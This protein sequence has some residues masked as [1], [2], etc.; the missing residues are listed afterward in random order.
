MRDLYVLA[1]VALSVGMGFTESD[2]IGSRRAAQPGVD[3]AAA[4]LFSPSI[5]QKAASGQDKSDSRVKADDWIDH[6]R[7]SGN[8]QTVSHDTLKKI[9]KPAAEGPSDER[10][11]IAGLIPDDIVTV[12]LSGS[13][14]IVD[15]GG[16]ITITAAISQDM[17]TDVI[18]P[19]MVKSGGSAEPG[20]YGS[21]P[22]I[23]IPGA[24]NITSATGILSIPVETDASDRDDEEF[25]LT[26]D[27]ARL[28]IT[29][30]PGRQRSV[31]VTILDS[32]RPKLVLNRSSIDP[33]REGSSETFSVR[34]TKQPFGR[35][36]RVRLTQRSGET[37]PV[38]LDKTELEFTKSTWNTDQVVTVSHTDNRTIDTDAILHIDLEVLG[39]TVR[40]TGYVELHFKDDDKPRI[41]L[42]VSPNPVDEGGSI[43]VTAEISEDPAADV[44]VPLTILPGGSAE[45]DDYGPLPTITIAGT[46]NVMTGTGTLTIPIE[47]DVN[48]RDDETFTVA[49]DEGGLSATVAAGNPKSVDVTILDSARPKLVLSPSAI[50]PFHEGSSE[51]F[52]VRLTREP[53]GRRA[54]VNL[55]QRP[56]EA[57]PVTLDKNELEFTKSNWNM[58]QMV[59][60]SHADNHTIDTDAT[61]HID[62]E[63]LG[64][65][66][67]RTDYVELHFK[68]DDKPKI[69]LSASPNPVDE[70]EKV[71]ITATISED[72]VTDVSIT[73][74]ITAGTAEPSDYGSISGG[75]IT[76]RGTGNTTTGRFIISTLEDDTEQDDETFTVT[77]GRLPQG[78]VAGDPSEIEIKIIDDDKVTVTLSASPNPVDEG[79]SVIVTATI[80]EDPASDVTIPLLLTAG[81]A[82]AGDYGILPS[83]TI[84]GAGNVTTGTGTVSIPQESDAADWEDETFTVAI[85]ESN[86]PPAVITGNPKSILIT[87][88]DDD[89]PTVS[90]SAS[91]NPVDEGSSVTVTAAIS[92]DPASDIVIPLTLTAGTA[93]TG[94][95]D[96]LPSITIPGAGSITTGTG[97]ITIPQES[98]ASDWEDETF[99]VAIDESSLPS[100]VTAGVRKSMLITI[101]DDDK[102]TVS[103]SAS[104][105]PVDEGS[106]VTV[107]VTISEDP[108]T[109]MVI[110]LTLTAG[111]AET[112]DYGALPDITIPGAGMIMTGTGI[113][114]LPQESDAS[115]WEDETF[116]VAIDE[117]N[118]PST[119]VP[120]LPKSALIQIID[121]DKPV[122]RLSASPNPVDEGQSV[123]V[124]ATISGDPATD[125]MVPLLLTAGTA[126]AGDYGVLPSITIPGAG[127]VR[128]GTGTITI[129]Q[130]SDVLDWEDET[131]AIAIHEGGLPATVIAGN[132][133]SIL[134]T[135]TDDDK[136][137]ITLTA[138]PNPILEGASS[139]VVITATI[140]KDPVTDMIIPLTLTS[141]TAEAGDYSVL[142]SITIPGAGNVRTGTGTISIPQESD[143]LDEE[144]ETFTVAI[145]EGHLPHTVIAGNP[146]S[147]LI[148]ITD[149]EKPTIV[150]YANPNRVPEGSTLRLAVALVPPPSFP[151]NTEVRVPVRII[152]GTAQPQDYGSPP[153]RVMITIPP[154][155]YSGRQEFPIPADADTG[156]ETFTAV[157]DE[158]GIDPRVRAGDMTLQVVT[159]TG[160][161]AVHL[162]ATTP[163]GEGD[164]VEVT[165][166]LTGTPLPRGELIPLTLTPVTAEEEDYGKVNTISIPLLPNNRIARGTIRTYPDTD[167]DDDTFTVEIDASSLPSTVVAG[168]PTSVLVTIS[169]KPTITLTASPNPVNEGESV[170]ISAGIS[171]DPVSDLTI[172]LEITAGTAEPGD[173]GMPADITIPGAGS[174]TTGTAR[175]N[176]PQESDVNDWEDETFTVSIDERNLPSTVI[177]GNPKS[178]LITITDD[179]K[180]AIILSASPNPVDEGGA[181]TITAEIAKVPTVD[182]TIPLTITA[183]TAEPSD[184]G[185]L[186]TSSITIPGVGA[187]MTGTVVIG[188]VE[189][190]D[191]IA[192]ETFT[193]AIHESGLPSTVIAGT[194]KVVEVTITDND[195]GKIMAPESAVVDEG[196]VHTFDVALSA[197]PL[198]NVTVTITGHAGTDLALDAAE[199]M[200]T[201]FNWDDAQT[202]TLTAAEDDQDL[203]DDTVILT[204]LAKDG[205]YDTSHEVAVTIT[206][207]DK[208]K[209]SAPESVVVNEGSTN[210]LDV[211]LM[212]QPSDNVTV[213]ITG[214]RNT[215]LVVD[216]EELIFTDSNWN[217]AQTVTLT[218]IN[219]DDALNDAV[220]LTLLATGGGYNA[221]HEVAVTI[222]DNDKAKISA[223]ESVA[224]VEGNTNTLDIA[225]TAQP[226]G[227]VTVMITG[228]AGTDLALDAEVLMFTDSNWDAAQTITLTAA[229]DDQD[230]SNDAVTLTLLATG[231]GYDASQ[232]VAVTITDNDKAGIS[233][234]E[235]VLVDEGST[236]TLDVVLTA[237]PSDNVTVAI[238]GHRNTALVLDLE[239]LI[240]TDSNWNVAQTLTLTAAED[241]NASNEAVSLTLLATGGGYHTSHET[242]VIIVDDD[243]VK[244]RLSANPHSVVEGNTIM[245]T[246]TLS[247]VLSNEAQIN[248]IYFDSTTEPGDYVPLESITITEGALAGSGEIPTNND[249]VFE[250]DETFRVILGALPPGTEAGSPSSVE[251][252]ITEDG[253]PPPPVEVTLFVDPEEVD[254]G[255]P[256][257]VTAMLT[258]ALN[259][260]LVIPLE[261][262]NSTNAAPE[263]GDYTPLPSVTIS[264]GQREGSGQIT[265]VWDLDTENETFIV[266]LGSPLPAELAPGRPSSQPVTIRERGPPQ[267]VT[268]HL[269][270]DPNPVNE[271][272]P[273]TVTA[274]LSRGFHT[275]MIIPLTVT[276]GT[277][278]AQDYQTRSPVQMEVS[279]GE[280]SGSYTISTVQD[281]VME[282]DENFTVKLG[283]LPSG[284]IAGAPSQIEVI[285]T[286][287]DEAGIK[288]P[289][290]VSVVEGATG[291]FSI[292]LNSEPLDE[293]VVE[294]TW[295]AG[296]DLTLGPIMSTF[297]S[298]N[299][300]QA[301]EITLHA[302]GDD[303]L[304][305]D[306]IWVTLT[307]TGTGY[308]GISRTVSV[309]IIDRDAPGIDAR[310]RITVP[311][312]S[313]EESEIALAQ[314]PSSTVTVTV[315]SPVGDLTV[316]PADLIFRP[317][318][319]Q[320]PQR[321]TLTAAEDDD[322]VNDSEVLTLRADG[323]GYTGVVRSVNVT[324]IDNDEVQ[325]LAPEEVRIEEGDTYPFA[326]NLSAQPS[327]PMTLSIIGHTGTDLIL[328]QTSLTFTRMN[329]RILQTV[330]LTTREDADFEDDHITLTLTASGGGYEITHTARVTITDDDQRP[331]ALM[332]S[333]YDERGFENA[334]SLHLHIEL[335]RPSDEIV[336]VQYASSDIEAEAGLDY[337]A[338]RGVVIFDPGATRGVIEIAILDDDLPEGEERFGVTLSNPRGAII[339][340]GTGT[341]MI[342][343]DDGSAI[344]RVEDAL[345]SEEEGMVRFRVSLSPPQRQRVTVAYQ[346]QDGT[347]K[348]GEDYEATSGIVTIAPGAVEAVIAV[349][350]L[351]GGADWRE[352]TFTVHLI[353]SKHAEIAKGIGTATIQETTTVSERVMEAYTAR[354]VRTSSMQ[355]VNALGNRFRST[356]DGAMCA[357][358]ERAKMA[359]LWYSTSSWDPSLGEILAGCRMYQS[360]TLSGGSFS[361]WGHGAFRQFNGQGDDALTLR[362]EVTTGIL[363]ADYRMQKMGGGSWLL[364]ILLAHSQGDGSFGVHDQSDEIT[365]G[366]TGVYPYVSYSRMGWNVW[367][368]TGAGR[369]NAEVLQLKGSLVSRFGAMGVRGILAQAGIV[370]LRYHG[371]ILVTGAEIKDHN[372]MTEIYRIRAGLEMTTQ[373]TGGI[374]PYV[375]ANVRQDGGS[376][377]TGTGLEFGGGIRFANPA[378]YLRGDVHTQGLVMHTADGF[379][380]WGISG[381][382][383]VGSRSEGVMASLRPSW[384]RSQG[385]SIYRQ[386]TILDAVPLGAAAH[387][388]ELELGYSVPWEDGVARS[389]MGMTRLPW[390]MMYRLGGELHPWERFTLSVFGLAHGGEAKLGNLSVN[391]RGSLRY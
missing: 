159:I 135:I 272:A 19:L 320:M 138:S 21:L 68:D 311:E 273:V 136:P 258:G 322:F 28:S 298:G 299:W 389:V 328:N 285:I 357:A 126:E 333:I 114:P 213:T 241:N 170:V 94:D 267:E 327:E 383:Q 78:V 99:T 260:D 261:Y 294:L 330:T 130:E 227:N 180:P 312:G 51:T 281:Y 161:P 25:T 52:N 352:E 233:A 184:Y 176:I 1:L 321:I 282:G 205:G 104:P 32:A 36:A 314:K 207:N 375:E 15:E 253:D 81:T 362:G 183:G 73:F 342:M 179:D 121:D 76:I 147:I 219:D 22:T 335:N 85:D 293:V 204:L 197:Q 145:N 154:K 182:V 38:T 344:L 62:L 144:D 262:N 242:A 386:Q 162:S 206:D 347:A 353:S 137:T 23:T 65:A 105:N 133:K 239:E 325:I 59:T 216:L 187:N 214:Y 79:S 74:T 80:S 368:S 319:W 63:V 152:P 302:T 338:S 306:H 160:A 157:I 235:S 343:E 332:I 289:E 96:A 228:H 34:L 60:V 8:S 211:V 254:E 276:G 148:T 26:I 193:V 31:D 70:G 345:V 24:G 106:S 247:E 89:K 66:V 192:N 14:T 64:G 172:H 218:A 326:V 45:S 324:I 171:E 91:P 6:F 151:L 387:R 224:V 92:A 280:T 309:T 381:S 304:I 373:I 279:A 359:Q 259:T 83:I 169:E 249:I 9:L 95:Y 388:T 317:D 266:A 229:E 18:V 296:T 87:I 131:F 255:D 146:K 123:T 264:R 77:L 143:A 53:L 360:L 350:I 16:S 173:Y 274:V 363:G 390:G 71:T 305:D 269:L 196:D 354:F 290:S 54:R 185:N 30:A 57:V 257:T 238:T 37:V 355:I 55:S 48:D 117:I 265:T 334:G 251:L 69:T 119:V 17:P 287:N 286:D 194:P 13:P 374:H 93:E 132:P 244:V 243:D 88:T 12:T 41:T 198:D 323:G 7:V 358:A 336:T 199:L 209:L 112:G 27:E 72:P 84:P 186:F 56:R 315:S 50:D 110:P 125:V 371:D 382:L 292:S 101:T 291:T 268:I 203:S 283:T 174:A 191:G 43:T 366:V 379:T 58:D 391:V 270:A 245:L 103:L 195:D 384:G 111:T 175:I 35:R 168:S 365:S 97:T 380:E 155:K 252:T 107:T 349:P 109:D 39:G 339:A 82:E 158:H 212:A 5:A 3:F 221:S 177:A 40:R 295:P 370:G 29:V 369:G 115:D 223:P 113:I 188:I 108:A 181:V 230:L 129:P 116:T 356:A 42:S 142:P 277:A 165:V 378:W 201:D 377:E 364:G 4:N 166:T 122:I 308:T 284:I 124:T 248:L 340:R 331:E 237:Q 164:D 222:T 337:T 10:T 44:I 156:D 141:G 236:N 367:L 47:T 90:L 167:P 329:W 46:G 256:V 100:T 300:D 275:D 120:G 303:D 310:A 33:F 86:L 232:D 215:D 140:S 128:T 153:R 348:A 118:L 190:D 49:I 150:L 231:G 139:G 2:R 271:G 210:T 307:A 102:P 341:G 127:N 250:G 288:S 313:S 98:D 376:A 163:V 67:R 11:M 316:T 200:F 318:N 208:A 301:Q 178:V 134:I 225:L 189:D 372:I 263:P 20:D 217:I 351:K 361:V 246:A 220:T 385:M 278:D 75:G 297:G 61:L 202:V 346:T 234:P 226:S 240:F 149:D